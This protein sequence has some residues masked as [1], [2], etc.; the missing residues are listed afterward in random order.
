M[1]TLSLT[2]ANAVIMLTVTPIFNAPQQ[3]KQF[4][5]DDVF[6]TPAIQSAEIAMGVDG[7]LSAGFVFVPVPQSYVLQANSPSNTIFDNWWAANQSAQDV[8]RADG[9][10]T[11]ISVG[12]KWNMANG[13]LTEYSP[14]PDAK[15]ILQPRRYTITWE[16]MLPSQI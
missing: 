1:P 5:A 16:S 14:A 13:V 3:L 9:V 11:L 10:I 8:Y 2:A 7:N 15:R 12:K 6:S 4:A